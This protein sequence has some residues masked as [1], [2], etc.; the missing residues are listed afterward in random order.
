MMQQGSTSRAATGAH[1][2]SRIVVEDDPCPLKPQPV[3]GTRGTIEFAGARI[4]TLD[5]AEI[6]GRGVV[7]VMEGRRVFEHLTVEENILTG[8]Y[9][10]RDARAVQQDLEGVY[11]YFPPLRERRR[12]R[13]GYISGGE[14][15]MLAI[16]RALM[17]RP[18]LMLLDEPSM[19]LA[20]M[21][22][23]EIFNIIVRLTGGA[24]IQCH[25]S[26]L[27]DVPVSDNLKRSGRVLF[28]E[29]DRGTASMLAANEDVNEFYLGL[30]A[31]GQ[32]RGYRDIKHYRRR[33]RWLS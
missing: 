30:S 4:D 22:V 2:S 15:Q 23:S 27:E 33:K 3:C 26:A 7:Q 5:P 24:G 16:G 10:R 11:H 12:V 21:I 17:A 29:Q 13:A 32:R 18:R 9:V 14:Q 28:G 19:A 20:P 8:A 1:S 6:V 31:V 25:P